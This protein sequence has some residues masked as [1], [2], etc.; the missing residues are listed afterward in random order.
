MCPNKLPELIFTKPS[1]YGKNIA[2]FSIQ[3]FEKRFMKKLVK[4][5]TVILTILSAILLFSSCE[6]KSP[7]A[8]KTATPQTPTTPQPPATP[9]PS[10]PPQP[11]TI[12]VGAPTTM[13][14]AK[15]VMVTVELDFGKG[16]MPTIA[17]AVKQIERQYQPD[18][19]VGRTFSI[20]D[21]Y[22][23]PTPD[24]K[25]LHIQMHVSSEKPGKGKLV[26]KRT[27]EV[28]W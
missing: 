3:F 16:K 18:D 7:P 6:Q 12:P 21:A 13:E 15:A 5:W 22:G 1:R 14:V 28:L 27:G 17:E 4:Q 10:T 20:L 25:L 9:Q 8:N 11:S 19:R 26:F 23:Q 24:G 2:S